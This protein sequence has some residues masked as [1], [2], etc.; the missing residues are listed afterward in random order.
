MDTTAHVPR[1]QNQLLPH[2][3]SIACGGAPKFRNSL[4]FNCLL[5]HLPNCSFLSSACLPGMGPFPPPNL[6]R[7]TVPL[8]SWRSHLTVSVRPGHSGQQSHR[9]RVHWLA[10]EAFVCA[11]RTPSSRQRAPSGA[12]RTLGALPV[13]PCPPQ[14]SMHNT[15]PQHTAPS[16]WS[17]VQPHCP[18]ALAAVGAPPEQPRHRP[19]AAD[20]QTAACRT[21]PPECPC[22]PA[23]PGLLCAHTLP[24][25]CAER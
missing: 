17:A 2:G 8:E 13:F 23:A 9:Y 12:L 6:H 1:Q 22:V 10:D 5:A 3:R 14:S 19:P 16:G 18:A 21:A 15:A 4:S 25:W 7:S 20:R 11:L 24:G